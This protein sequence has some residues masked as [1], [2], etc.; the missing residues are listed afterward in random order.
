MTYSFKLQTV[1]DHRQFLED[2]LKKELANLRQ[3]A[4]AAEDRLNMLLKKEA[5]TQSTLA[6]RQREGLAS[7]QAVAYHAY[8]Q[9]LGREIDSQRGEIDAISERVIKK[10]EDVLAA[11]KNRQI[12][13]RLKE[14]DVERY[15]TIRQ[16]KEAAFVDEIA[17][18]RFARRQT[19][20]LGKDD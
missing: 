11:M 5:Q 15:N 20:R 14:T 18:N 13:E 6:G 19:N 1:L 7:D 10:Q 16:R 2:N 17:V 12:L 9:R 8:L 3:L 4:D